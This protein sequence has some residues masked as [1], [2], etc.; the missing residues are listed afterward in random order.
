MDAMLTLQ[1]ARLLTERDEKLLPPMLAATLANVARFDAWRI[2]IVDVDG[3]VSVVDFRNN[4]RTVC[5]E[6]GA[7]LSADPIHQ[8]AQRSIGDGFYSSRE[9]APNGLHRTEYY[10]KASQLGLFFTDHA[11]YVARIDE[12][13]AIC[14]SFSRTDHY[15]MFTATENDRFRAISPLILHALKLI[16]NGRMAT[17]ENVIEK[18]SDDA[19]NRQDAALQSFGST[20]LT[21]RERDVTQ[22]LI[23]GD[24]AKMIAREL[25][26]GPGTARNHIKHIYMKLGIS[27]RN[28]LFNRYM[29]ELMLSEA[30]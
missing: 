20:T 17:P 28:E 4:L 14:I 7:N 19:K 24:S 27:S 29:Q 21:P 12:M 3:D 9:L 22:R 5:W 23:A 13:R 10:K 25:G 6:R 11:G 18:R 30:A 16:W 8:I 26:I 15:A 1:Y 2:M